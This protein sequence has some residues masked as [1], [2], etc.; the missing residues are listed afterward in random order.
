MPALSKQ[1]SEFNRKTAKQCFNKTWDYLEKK[2]RTPDDDRQMLI[3]AHASRYHWGLVGNARNLAVGEWQISRVYADL[4]Q[5][6]PSLLFAK[7]S[8]ELMI[9]NNLSD[10][11]PSAYEGLARAHAI[12][13]QPQPARDYIVKARKELESIKDEEDREFYSEQINETESLLQLK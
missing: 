4:K 10:L 3:L 5:A 6:E 12:A 9:K 2:N 13:R 7:S 1:E 8:L 11:L